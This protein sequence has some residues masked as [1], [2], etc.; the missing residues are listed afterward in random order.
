LFADFNCGD[1]NRR[2]VESQGFSVF[3]L[4]R[5]RRSGRNVKAA[6]LGGLYWFC[7]GRRR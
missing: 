3:F 2:D 7:G 4:K 5:N 6:K 1:Y